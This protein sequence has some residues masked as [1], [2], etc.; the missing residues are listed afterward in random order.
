MNKIFLCL[1]LIITTVYIESNDKLYFC[2]ASNYRYYKYLINLIGSIHRVN[3]DD[4]GE[5]AVFDLG[6]TQE[7]LKELE[8]IEKVKVYK[9]EPTNPEILNPLPKFPGS[10]ELIPGLYS[11]KP[12]VLKQALEMFPYVQ[13]IDAGMAIT[14]PF[15]HIFDQ[16]KSQGYFLIS[17]NHSIGWMTNK[18]II[19]KLNLMSPQRA[20]IL[21]TDGISAGFQ[22][23]SKAKLQDYLMPIYELSKD[24]KNFIDYGTIYGGFN[25]RHDQ[26]LFSIQARLCGMH[27]NSQDRS[28][29]EFGTRWDNRTN[30]L[31]FV[32]YKK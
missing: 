9:V 14:R 12:V 2:T 25:G 19:E 24:L 21:G 23:L 22:G 5:I 32:R 11:W 8:N 30:Y 20:W 3:F 17:C 4:L 27:I 10:Q 26:T 29:L 15:N 31:N 13:Y 6:M 7:E 28:Y 1:L 18:Y 16:I